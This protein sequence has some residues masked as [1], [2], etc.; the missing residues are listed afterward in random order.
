MKKPARKNDNKR[1]NTKIN[2][3]ENQNKNQNKNKED[4]TKKKGFWKRHKLLAKFLKIV[5][6]LCLLLFIIGVG[7][8][9][10]IFNSDQWNMTESDLTY[11]NV[12]TVIYDAE[13]NEI[14]NMAGAERRRVVQLS[15]VPKYLQDAYISIEDERF[16]KHNGVDIKRTLAVTVKYI[17][18]KGNSSSG[19][20][21]TITQQTVKNFMNDKD[22]SGLGGIKRKIREMSR[23]IKLEK[24]LSK[25][26]ILELYLNLIF[27]GGPGIHGVE[28]GSQYYFNK[29]VKDLDLA[30]CAFLAGINNAP[31]SYNPFGEEDNSE[32]I[33]KRTKTVLAKM[34]EL[35]KITEEEYNTA[36][37]EVEAGLKFEQGETTTNVSMS[38]LARAAFNQVVED[39]AKE[40]EIDEKTAASLIEGKGYKIYTTQNSSI[41]ASLEEVYRSGDYVYPGNKTDSEGNLINEHTQSAMVII[42]HKTGYVVGCMGGLGDDVDSNGLNRATQSARQPGSSMKPIASIAP[43]LEAG[44]INAATIYDES[45]TSFGSYHPTSSRVGLITVRKAIEISANTTECKIMSELGPRNSIEFLRKMG[46]TTLVTAD[47]NSEHND[48]NLPMVLGG[49]TIG[50][51]PLEMAGAYATIANDGVYITPTFYT[52]VEDSSGNVI[53]EAKQEKTRV[54]SEANA[55]IEKSILTGPVVGAGGT[56][57]RC[58]IPNQETAGKTGTT[59]S[60]VDRW[61]C[62]FTSYY[63]AATWYGYDRDQERLTGYANSTNRSCQLWAEVMKKIHEDLPESSFTKPSSVVTARICLQSGKVATEACS[64]TYTEYFAKGTIPSDCEGHTKLT[65]CTDTGKIATEHCPNTEEKNYTKKPEKEELTLWNT[66]DG[67]KYD[68]PTETCDVHTAKTVVMPNIIEKSKD[69]AMKILKDLGLKVIIETKTSNKEDGEVIEQSKST[70]TTIKIG[71]TVTITVSKKSGETDGDN[72]SENV[73][74]PDNPENTEI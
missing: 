74:K 39:Y 32:L 23:A 8:I 71:D 63:T 19:G 55:F 29:S 45:S 37:D 4:K 2:K 27:V 5:I 50:I 72:T 54:M 28:L 16:E 10:A 11:S 46:I 25:S 66:D 51:S 70:G 3:K 22:D 65:I 12:N 30:E 7:I 15:E 64:Q 73:I 24:Q 34:K 14:A 69:E 9:V 18:H 41:Q 40:K 1:N 13:G 36:K 67:G 59:T 35:G 52:K 56:A 6:I 21:S 48:E 20:G 44:I 60:N 58:K 53:L 33:K 62:G 43:A 57:S 31:N 47:E 68:I 49:L 26:Q 38:Y 17:L 42:D 61:F